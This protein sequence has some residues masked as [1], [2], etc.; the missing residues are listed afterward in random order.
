MVIP[1]H[2]FCCLVEVE[3]RHKIC[4]GS[5]IKVTAWNIWRMLIWNLWN[6]IHPFTSTLPWKPWRSHGFGHKHRQAFSLEVNRLFKTKSGQISSCIFNHNRRKQRWDKLDVDIAACDSTHGN[7][8]TSLWR[9]TLSTLNNEMENQH[10]TGT[11]SSS[12]LFY[13]FK[14]RICNIMYRILRYDT[15]NIELKTI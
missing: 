11:S 12:L 10:R 14:S 3:K 15:Q 7:L 8:V 9:N 5:R 2:Q 1:S 4:F 6:N 13:T